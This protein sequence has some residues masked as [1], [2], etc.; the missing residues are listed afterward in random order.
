MTDASPRIAIRDFA[1]AAPGVIPAMTELAKAID[2]S[3][4][5]KSLGELL[6]I[7]ASQINGCA[8]CLQYHLLVAHKLDIPAIKID[9]VAAWHDSPVYT[10]R[11]RAALAWTEVLTAMSTRPDTDSAYQALQEQFSPT[12]IANLTTAIAQINAWNRIAGSLHFAPDIPATHTAP[13]T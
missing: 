4:L 10:P 3:G 13:S 12:E 9:L 5:D 11:E 7:R 2:A 8:Y 6:K 1:K